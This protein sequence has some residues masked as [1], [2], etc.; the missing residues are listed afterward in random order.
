MTWRSWSW[1]AA[2][3]AAGRC[4]WLSLIAAGPRLDTAGHPELDPATEAR[5]AG[6]PALAEAD[7]ADMHRFLD[8]WQGDLRS[9]LG[10]GA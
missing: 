6:T 8:D 2:I 3:A 4:R 1:R 9:L 10:G 7:V 5:L